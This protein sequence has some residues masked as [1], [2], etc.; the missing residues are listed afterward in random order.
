M[1]SG[2]VRI[3]F[4][5]LLRISAI[6]QVVIKRAA[7]GAERIGV[8][9]LLAE[10]EPASPGVVEKNPIAAPAANREKE[11]DALVDGIDRFLRTDVSIPECVGL[12]SAVE[13]SC[14]VAQSEVMFVG[15][16][17]LVDGETASWN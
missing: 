6:D 13:S 10:V 12:V 11:R 9:R 1:G 16:H 14:L 2:E 4:D 15:G 7:F 8:A 5:H 17:G 3:S